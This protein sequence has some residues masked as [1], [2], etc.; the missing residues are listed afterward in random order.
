MEADCG[1]YDNPHCETIYALLTRY[2]QATARG[3]SSKPYESEAALLFARHRE[4]A[5]DWLASVG[6]L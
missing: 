5:A 6:L 3:N 4:L 2:E 1:N